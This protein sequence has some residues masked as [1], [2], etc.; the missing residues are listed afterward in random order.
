MYVGQTEP[1]PLLLSGWSKAVELNGFGA[2]IDWSLY[3][4]LHLADGTKQWAYYVP[5][6]P[7]K[8]GWQH[9]YGESS[10]RA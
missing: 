1:A 6:D 4:D 5:F 8:H 3:A 7:V 9:V 10:R 2:P